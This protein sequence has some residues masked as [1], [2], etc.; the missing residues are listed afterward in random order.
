MGKMEVIATQWQDVVSDPRYKDFLKF[1]VNIQILVI[2][3]I[4]SHVFRTI[5]ISRVGN[6]HKVQNIL[7]IDLAKN[8]FSEPLLLF[9]MQ[10]LNS[11]HNSDVFSVKI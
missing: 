4:L 2:K 10:L 9:I 8:F 6:Q 7:S 5:T 1:K 11:Q 3:S